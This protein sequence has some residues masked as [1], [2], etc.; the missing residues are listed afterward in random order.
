MDKMRTALA[1]IFRSDLQFRLLGYLASGRETSIRELST[2]IDA[3][4]GA[5]WA[6]VERLLELGTLEERRVGRSKLVRLAEGPSYMEPLRR[7]LLQTYGPLPFLRDELQMIEDVTEAF[8][9]GSW[10]RRYEGEIGP[11]PADVDVF[12]VMAPSSDPHPVYGAC[13]RVT[14][15]TEQTVNATVLTATEWEGGDSAFVET[16]RAGPRV[17]VLGDEYGKVF[18]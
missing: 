7:L 16:V 17:G 8:V 11:P 5:T 12:V 15:R 4:Y 6:E 10:A 13:S 9:Y 2:A 18:P 1:P 14:E 3:S